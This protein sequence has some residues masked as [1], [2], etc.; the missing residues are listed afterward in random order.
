MEWTVQ[1]HPDNGLVYLIGTDVTERTH[2][3]EELRD[4]EERGRALF[5]NAAQA[6]ISVDA[7]GRIRTMNPMA[8][9]LFGYEHQEISGHSL[10]V[11]MPDAMRAAHRRHVEG[12]FEEPHTRPMGLGLD[13]DGRRKDGSEFPVEISLSHIETKEGSIAVAFVNDITEMQK[14]ISK[15]RYDVLEARDGDD[16]CRVAAEHGGPIDVVVTDVVMPR[17]NGP[18]V[19]K[20]VRQGRPDVKV[21]YMSGHADD[22]LVHHGVIEEGLAFLEK[23]FTRAE[24]T[25]RVRDVL[26]EH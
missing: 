12:F 5:D 23:P 25:K 19:V 24:L 17:M 15:R 8:E 7:R 14:A 10:D 21:V 18:A 11:L 1:A 2:V 3:E 13:L 9:K 4:S 20:E 22:T 26:D 6:I 16:A